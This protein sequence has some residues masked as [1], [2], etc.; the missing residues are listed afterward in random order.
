M[1]YFNEHKIINK[2]TLFTNYIWNIYSNKK[3]LIL[4]NYRLQITKQVHN[5]FKC[6]FDVIMM[7]DFYQAFHVWDLWILK[8]KIEF[9]ILGQFGMNISN[10]MNYNMSCAKTINNSSIF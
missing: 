3:M 10:V 2:P 5:E 8:G 4:I 7:G 1:W 6:D 9:N